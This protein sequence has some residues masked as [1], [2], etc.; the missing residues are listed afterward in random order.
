MS[1]RIFLLAAYRLLLTM[2]PTECCN[3]YNAALTVTAG[4]QSN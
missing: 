4:E 2:P 1:N 3:Q